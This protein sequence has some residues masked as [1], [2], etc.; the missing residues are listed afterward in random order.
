MAIS[1]FEKA[2]FKVL[3][4]KGSHCLLY[5]QG[6]PLLVIPVHLKDLKIGL[7]KKE[8]KKAGLTVEQFESLL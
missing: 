8:I 4:Q 2:G 6:T 5:K 7:L 3:R 1:A